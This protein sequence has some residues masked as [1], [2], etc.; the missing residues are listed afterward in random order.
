MNP[1]WDFL[2][3]WF[4]L[5]DVL[6]YTFCTSKSSVC[7]ACVNVLLFSGVLCGCCNA[8]FSETFFTSSCIPDEDCHP[9]PFWITYFLMIIFFTCYFCFL[10][11]LTLNLSS[12]K[13]ESAADDPT[14]V[15]FQG[16]EVEMIVG[17]EVDNAKVRTQPP[18]PK[19]GAQIMACV[20]SPES[21]CQTC[22]RIHIH[23]FSF[24]RLVE[25]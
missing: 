13:S 18:T 22:W 16:Q 21:F 11:Y 7:P 3:V 6:L 10:F 1:A 9:A 24:L 17:N 15:S 2:S 12:S 23:W 25:S 4:W 20:G 14:A 5:G 8:G 19:S